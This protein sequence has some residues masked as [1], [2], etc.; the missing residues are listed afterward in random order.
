M[1]FP[2]DSEEVLYVAGRMSG[3]PEHNL[4]LFNST[5]TALRAVG[6]HVENPADD[7]GDGT[8]D[9]ADYIRMALV[10]LMRSS[11]VALLDEWWLSPGAR[12]EV[13]VAGMLGMTIRT[14]EE[15]LARKAS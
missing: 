10:R 9:Y 4:P 15:W 12:L 8:T 7:E 3:V 6:Y 1:T 2:I 14:A 5:A 11:G 13:Q